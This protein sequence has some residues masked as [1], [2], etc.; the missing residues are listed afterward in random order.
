MCVIFFFFIYKGHKY[1]YTYITKVCLKAVTHTCVQIHTYANTFI[2]TSTFIYADKFFLVNWSSLENWSPFHHFYKCISIAND[3]LLM[4]HLRNLFAQNKYIAQNRKYL[5]FEVKCPIKRSVTCTTD[6]L[7]GEFA[8]THIPRR[9][10]FPVRHVPS[11]GYQSQ[12]I[13]CGFVFRPHQEH[14]YTPDV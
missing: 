6:W 1:I 9:Q 13:C 11:S 5:D 14:M 3:N 2:C 4:C 12:V 7:H 8:H 10:S